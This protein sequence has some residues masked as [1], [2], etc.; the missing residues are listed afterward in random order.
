MKKTLIIP[1][2]SSGVIIASAASILFANQK[3][4]LSQLMA[5]DSLIDHTI[6]LTKDNVVFSNDEGY[7]ELFK[8]NA[9]KN[10]DGFGTVGAIEDPGEFNYCYGDTM[11]IGGD[12]IFDL[13]STV[14]GT[15]YAPSFFII[16]FWFDNVAEYTSI[17]FNGEFYDNPYK[18][19]PD[20]TLEFGPESISHDSFELDTTS[21]NHSKV[22]LD[23]IV[24][25]YKCA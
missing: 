17:V 19:S 5:G 8:N 15:Y 11:T 13:D 6:T 16:N 18:T 20:Y 14:Y 9:T 7:F 4:K 10:G 12:H 25:K 23:S 1:L 24:I 2:V 21:L 3:Q 22:I